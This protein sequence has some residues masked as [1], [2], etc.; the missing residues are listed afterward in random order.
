MISDVYFT[1]AATGLLK[2][3]EFEPRYKFHKLNKEEIY[4]PDA[5]FSWNG[6]TY[7]LEIQKKPLSIKDWERKNSYANR[8]FNEQH[9]EKVFEERYGKV[10][11]PHFLTISSQPVESVRSG[12]NV[13][14]RYLQVIKDVRVLIT[15]KATHV[16]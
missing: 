14:G 12:F 6:K 8:F 10:F 9:F 16:E 4:S 11:F 2:R 1:L 3:F 7:M 5:L 13:D 15:N